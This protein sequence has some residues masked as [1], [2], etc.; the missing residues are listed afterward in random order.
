MVLLTLNDF[1]LQGRLA[2]VKFKQAGSPAQY[3]GAHYHEYYEIELI[4]EGNTKYIID[5]KPYEGKPGDLFMLKPSSFHDTTFFEGTK[6]ITIMF[7]LNAGNLDFLSSLPADKSYIA[8]HLSDTDTN[9]IRILAQELETCM[10]KNPSADN[11]YATSVLN[12]ILGKIASLSDAQNSSKSTSAMS[13]AILYM[14]SH[15]TEDIT[16][17]QVANIANY[18]SNYFSTQFKQLT[19][20]SFKQYLTNTRYTFAKKLLRTTN[21]PVSDICHQC[22]FNDLSHFMTAFKKRY[23]MTPKQF[24]TN[25]QQKTEAK[26]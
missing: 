9:L 2:D 11:P 20:M 8:L 21:L 18:S 3:A 14:Q 4:L 22:G 5:G 26:S 10:S 7:P 17:N 24:R 19:G 16:L 6:F 15:F 1:A 25:M 13:R 23:G 12:C